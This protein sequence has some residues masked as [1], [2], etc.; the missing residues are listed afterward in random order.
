MFTLFQDFLMHAT[1]NDEDDGNKGD[2]RNKEDKDDEDGNVDISWIECWVNQPTGEQGH[3]HTETRP[4]WVKPDIL[5]TAG[6]TQSRYTCYMVSSFII[7]GLP[8]K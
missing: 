8:R 3:K 2:N 1:Y 7:E 5:K 6:I 4:G